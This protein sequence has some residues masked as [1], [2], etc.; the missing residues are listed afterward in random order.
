[1]ESENKS[2]FDEQFRGNILVVGKT[3]CGKTYNSWIT[4]ISDMIIATIYIIASLSQYFMSSKKLHIL[5]DIIIIL[6][7]KS[8]VLY[9]VIY[10]GKKLK[11][12]TMICFSNYQKTINIMKS[13]FQ[14]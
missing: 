13:N 12:N 11:K 10:S 4:Q 6:I 5:K 3:G 7:R 8:Q 1:M 2:I 9:Q 14:R